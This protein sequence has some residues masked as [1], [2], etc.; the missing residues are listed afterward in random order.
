MQTGKSKSKQK[1]REPY[2]R[3]TEVGQVPIALQEIKEI[4]FQVCQEISRN[5]A[6]KSTTTP[7][8]ISRLIDSIIA[9][10][11]ANP[12]CLS[13]MAE[14]LPHRE[15]EMITSGN[16]KPNFDLPAC[17]EGSFTCHGCDAVIEEDDSIPA[18]RVF[19]WVDVRT[20]RNNSYCFDCDWILLQDGA[21]PNAERNREVQS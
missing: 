12:G 13:Q 18:K 7:F 11:C 16:L 10:T 1:T 8:V 17:P 6:V 19:D 4:N 2:G 14:G 3:V 21:V 5:G 20:N 9:V 15:L